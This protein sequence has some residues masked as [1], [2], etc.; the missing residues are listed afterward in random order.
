[1][2]SRKR[3]L[4][5]ESPN[6]DATGDVEMRSDGE[7]DDFFVEPATGSA[8]K[9]RTKRRKSEGG[10]KILDQS[11]IPFTLD[12]AINKASTA[13][14]QK[15]KQR[16]AGEE[17]EETEVDQE[18]NEGEVGI[19]EEGDE[20][21]QEQEEEE[22]DFEFIMELPKLPTD[23]AG[24]MPP[25]YVT[26][27]WMKDNKGVELPQS[28]FYKEQFYLPFRT[29][30][31]QKLMRMMKEKGSQYK[32]Q[33][34]I[35]AAA[36]GQSVTK[37][38][39]KLMVKAMGAITGETVKWNKCLELWAPWVWIPVET[40][41]DVE[42]LHN[43]VVVW[44]DKT[45]RVQV[46]TFRKLVKKVSDKVTW[47]AHVDLEGGKKP[48]PKEI[49]DRIKQTDWVE[50]VEVKEAVG[51]RG[52]IIWCKKKQPLDPTGRFSIQIGRQKPMRFTVIR[53]VCVICKG[54]DH[55]QVGTP[56]NR[57]L[58]CPLVGAVGSLLGKEW[59]AWE[60]KMGED[61]VEE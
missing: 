57:E 56:Y 60:I 43:Q 9:K 42:K 2:S 17:E 3:A 40:K 34:G 52:F 19:V 4:P 27:K 14:K 41:E 39:K 48:K 28:I 47:L 33:K 21:E 37:E 23:G 51:G 8:K 16:E 10:K 29:E 13:N 11:P 15:G 12:E 30:D 38:K 45:E 50:K 61:E 20:T 31:Q 18:L 7:K 6:K 54:E 5:P 53:N 32:V 55:G 36:A 44:H 1:M 35:L 24:E 26:Q 25:K 59:V 49:E 46:V 22:E 58:P